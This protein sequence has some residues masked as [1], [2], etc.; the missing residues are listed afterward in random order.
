MNGWM[1]NIKTFSILIHEGNASESY[2]QI[3]SQTSKNGYGQGKK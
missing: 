2:F 1:Q 3:L